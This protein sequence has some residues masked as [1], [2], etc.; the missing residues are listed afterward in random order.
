MSY[1]RWKG[2]A[3]STKRLDLCEKRDEYHRHRSKVKRI[4]KK[5][6]LYDIMH[7]SGESTCRIQILLDFLCEMKKISTEIEG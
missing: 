4:I 1:R 5:V 3:R 7:K 2:G 6:I